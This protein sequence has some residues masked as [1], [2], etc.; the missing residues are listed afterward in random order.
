MRKTMMIVLAVLLI[1]FAQGALANAA[2]ADR[3]FQVLDCEYY[4]D[5]Q[6][7]GADGY[8]EARN[9]SGETVSVYTAT[10]MMYDS[11][12]RLVNTSEYAI[13]YPSIIKPGETFC[14]IDHDYDADYSRNE[15]ARFEIIFDTGTPY[16]EEVRF[17]DELQLHTQENNFV[18][19]VTN[20]TGKSIYR[21]GLNT[22]LRDSTGKIVYMGGNENPRM[23]G[24]CN[25]SSMEF[26]FYINDDVYERISGEMQVSASAFYYVDGITGGL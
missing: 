15:I 1:C 26:A 18:F 16:R 7:G 6:F 21:V 9:V 25:G 22:I 24:L 17:L 10:I 4:V 5:E 8:I 13:A 23:T 14:V 12:G 3:R 11:V 20:H 2:T 19:T